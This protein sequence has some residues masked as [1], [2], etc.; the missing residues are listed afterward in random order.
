MAIHHM[1]FQRF[2]GTHECAL[3]ICASMIAGLVPTPWKATAIETP[4]V[5]A[6]SSTL[7]KAASA[8]R[9]P[10]VDMGGRCIG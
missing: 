3:L 6:S 2:L 9:M 8:P 1:C 10:L 4:P 5:L 7:Y